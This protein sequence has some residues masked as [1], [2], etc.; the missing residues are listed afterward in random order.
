MVGPSE[1]PGSADA[2]PGET[3]AVASTQAPAT[4]AL[5]ATLEWKG[6]RRFRPAI[7]MQ[8]SWSRPRLDKENGIRESFVQ[9]MGAAPGAPDNGATA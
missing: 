2:I 9:P 1:D 7:F 3:I 4:S 6:D 8:F 5:T